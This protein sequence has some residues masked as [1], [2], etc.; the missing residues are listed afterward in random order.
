MRASRSR[1]RHVDRVFWVAWC[2]GTLAGSIAMIVARATGA[3]P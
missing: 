2:T 3:L 1:L